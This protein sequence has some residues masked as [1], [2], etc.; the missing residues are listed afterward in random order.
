[1]AVERV[2][3]HIAALGGQAVDLEVARDCPIGELKL[4]IA[5]QLGFARGRRINLVSEERTVLDSEVAW[6]LAE[7]PL[8]AVLATS[9]AEMMGPELAGDNEFGAGGVLA[10][11]GCIYFA[12]CN[13]RQV[14]CVNPEAGTAEMMGPELAGNFK[15]WAGGV[16]AANG[17]IY[18]APSCARQVL[19]MNS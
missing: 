14:L 10:A 16:L 18:F 17:C 7:L 3:L 8:Q 13:A 5:T 1:M 19:C 6:Q 9:A 4:L 11:N 12:P 2:S 15:F